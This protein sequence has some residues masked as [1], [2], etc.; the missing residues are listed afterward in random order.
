MIVSPSTQISGNA[1]PRHEGNIKQARAVHGF[2]HNPMSEHRQYDGQ[3]FASASTV[4][5]FHLT[6]P[7]LDSEEKAHARGSDTD[8]HSA[9]EAD[10]HLTSTLGSTESPDLAVNPAFCLLKLNCPVV[11][12]SPFAFMRR[13]S[14]LF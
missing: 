13:P 1:S 10:A 3:G 6:A 2:S 11:V 12:T 7:A 9:S 4:P 14:T 5:S 8:E